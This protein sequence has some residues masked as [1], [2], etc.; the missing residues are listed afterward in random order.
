MRNAASS[1]KTACWGQVENAT[2]GST[3]HQRRDESMSPSGV[4]V[5]GLICRS[6]YLPAVDAV[7]R[8]PFALAFRGALANQRIGRDA[9]RALQVGR[10]RRIL[11]HAR[12]HTPHYRALMARHR[13]DPAALTQLEDLHALPILEKEDVRQ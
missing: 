11:Q 10:L 9:M 2:W 8:V 5:Y 6:L 12:S 7:R 4:A 3:K 13:F 1:A